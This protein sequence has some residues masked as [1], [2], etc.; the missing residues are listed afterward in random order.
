MVYDL[1]WRWREADAMGGRTEDL[2]T[3]LM[4]WLDEKQIWAEWLSLN[5]DEKT[6]L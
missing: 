3:F 5:S 1:W 4:P 2:I 6:L